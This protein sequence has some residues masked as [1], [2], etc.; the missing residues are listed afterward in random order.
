MLYLNGRICG[1][2]GM[3]SDVVNLHP[4]LGWS[5]FF[6]A[7]MIAGGLLLNVVYPE[8]MAIEIPLSYPVIF[9]GGLLVGLGTR[10]GGGCTSGHGICGVGMGY[11][12]SIAATVVFVAV[13][14][15]TATIVYHY[16]IGD[17]R[18]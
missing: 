6:L 13:G 18:P 16:F 15:L 2:S 17:P 12:R 10:M 5:G 8:A 9:F 7:G 4:N 1:I 11:G 14:M 3:V